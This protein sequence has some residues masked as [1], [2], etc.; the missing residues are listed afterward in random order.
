MQQVTVVHRLEILVSTVVQLRKYKLCTVLS[1]W[2]TLQSV[3]DFCGRLF[4]SVASNL[5]LRLI[6]CKYEMFTMVKCHL[7][8]ILFIQFIQLS[9]RLF[10][11]RARHW[12]FRNINRERCY[13]PIRESTSRKSTVLTTSG[14]VPANI[15]AF[16]VRIFVWF[17]LND[18]I[19]SSKY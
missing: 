11:R 9:P 1:I 7:S 5:H 17:F 10:E 13:S 14:T 18:G 19:W 15:C 2:R 3:N 6:F 8:V 12:P 4:D 16:F